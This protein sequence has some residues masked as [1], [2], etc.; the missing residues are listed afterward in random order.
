MIKKRSQILIIAVLL[1]LTACV[2]NIF[3][4]HVSENIESIKINVRNF[5]NSESI[6]RTLAEVNADGVSFKWKENDTIGI[7]PTN[8]YQ[9]AFPMSL[10]AGAQNAE[11]DGGDWGLKASTQYTAYYPFEFYNR[12]N[13]NVSI[14]YT[15]QT[16]TGNATTD[17]IGQYDYMAAAATTP[18]EGNVSFNFEHLGALIQ[19]KIKMPEAD[20]F[21]K[22]TLRCDTPV[23]TQFGKLNLTKQP[24]QIEAIQKDKRTSIDL[25][26]IRTTT[27]D[28]EIVVYM[29]IAPTDL[30]GISYSVIISNEQGELKET[31]MEG[32]KFDAGKAYSINVENFEHYE[33][34]ELE[35][36][37]PSVLSIE[38]SRDTITLNYKT[39]TVVTCNISKDAQE[40]ITP[41]ES[42]SSTQQNMMFEIAENPN[43]TIRYGII[44]L[45]TLKG[46]ASISYTIM[47]GSPYSYAITEKGG[48][49]PIGKLSCNY[50]ATSNEHSLYALADDDIHT[51]FEV[52]NDTCEIIW[53]GSEIYPVIGFGIGL[54]T[55]MH[56]IN[57]LTIHHSND[58]INW[59]SNNWSM[60]IS[61]NIYPF[62]F[63]IKSQASAK[64]YKLIVA[65]NHGASTTRIPEFRLITDPDTKFDVDMDKI[66][67]ESKP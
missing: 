28:E 13:K 55:G 51:Y 9:V 23:F 50:P 53:E 1:T 17:H 24:L 40:W 29:M 4:D 12:S 11:F 44:T 63:K 10:G 58:G 49:L 26:N 21:T 20:N 18:K 67:E 46:D 6:S 31:K 52:A 65:K 36:I 57:N 56:Q 39:N 3:K 60:E 22:L 54:G 62:C 61:T 7:F 8:G 27:A 48:A 66:Q 5:I 38:G 2:D 41:I 35:L 37:G 47:Q 34:E 15:G 14:S 32:K 45:T 19:W 59:G 64:F 42:R 33:E 25:K 16:Q 43:Y 30:T